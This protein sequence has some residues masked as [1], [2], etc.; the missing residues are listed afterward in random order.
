MKIPE[1]VEKTKSSREIVEESL[2]TSGFPVD[3]SKNY[4]RDEVRIAELYIRYLVLMQD[5]TDSSSW[6]K[7]SDGEESI[8]K[9]LVNENIRNT[10]AIWFKRWEEELE[11][12]REKERRGQYS[13]FYIRKR[14]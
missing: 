14:A 9:T 12:Y 3:D 4:N 2:L 5:A 7:Y 1:I 6:F 10:A 8:D 13:S 11:R